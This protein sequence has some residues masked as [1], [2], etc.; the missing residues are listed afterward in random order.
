MPE[1]SVNLHEED[2]I[3]SECAAAVNHSRGNSSYF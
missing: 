2:V 1:I 3:C